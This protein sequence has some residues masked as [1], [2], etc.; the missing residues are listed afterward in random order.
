MIG[1]TDMGQSDK[2]LRNLR[3]V[4]LITEEHEID[5]CECMELLDQYVDVLNGGADP[6]QVL[7]EIEQH[8][9]LCDCCHTELEAL[10]IA[11]KIAMETEDD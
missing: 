11:V 6:A 9:K 8:L 3:N 1:K 5:C 10:V 2:F 4:S 7:P